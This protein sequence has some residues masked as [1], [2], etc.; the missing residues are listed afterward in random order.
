MKVVARVDANS[1]EIRVKFPDG[2]DERYGTVMLKNVEWG[3]GMVRGTLV[4]VFKHR[5]PNK[6]LKKRAY[7]NRNKVSRYVDKETGKI[8]TET[9]GAYM[10]G[11]A[12]LYVD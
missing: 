4:E 7:F 12:V 11:S 8:L 10:V 6:H 1:K 3:S 2:R 9:S 5:V